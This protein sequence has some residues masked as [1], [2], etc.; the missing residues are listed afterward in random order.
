MYKCPKSK[1]HKE[2]L[3]T[4]HVTQDWLVDEA[5]NFMKCESECVEVLV[6]PGRDVLGI[7]KECN[8]EATW[9]E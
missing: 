6:S 3:V 8:E 2:F 4:T 5:G 9:E 7:C 1:N